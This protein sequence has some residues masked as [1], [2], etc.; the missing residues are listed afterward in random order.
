MTASGEVWSPSDFT[1]SPHP[2]P[3]SSKPK[4]PVKLGGRL[5]RT[6]SGWQLADAFTAIA[7]SGFLPDNCQAGDLLLLQGSMI[8]ERFECTSG[9]LVLHPTCPPVE[10]ERLQLNGLG[11]RLASRSWLFQKI[12]EFFATRRFI[13]V[14]TPIRTLER[15]LEENIQPLA[16]G[17]SLLITSPELHMK[18]LLV[19]GVPRLFELVHCFRDGEKGQLHH[20]EFLMLEWYRA[21][22]DQQAVMRDTEELLQ[23]LCFQLHGNSHLT[24]WGG[25]EIDLSTPFETLTIREV[26]RRFGGIDDAVKLASEDENQYFQVLV[27]SVEP[28][29]AQFSK[30][31]FLCEYPASQAALARL[32]PQDPTVA[33][34]FELYVGGVELCNGYGE[35]NDADEQRRRMQQQL[36]RATRSEQPQNQPPGPAPKLP[37]R[38]LSALDQGMPPAGG[39]A[40]GVDRLMALLTGQAAIDA[41]MPFAEFPA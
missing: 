21:F 23:A 17:E 26:F 30:P 31:V 3:S 20:P 41:V 36:A 22:S 32:K 6:A 5:Q 1:A 40:L 7:L 15:C 8:E 24:L 11:S 10:F 13:E 18:R 37:Q 9:E 12:R 34:R 29:L 39:N 33:E 14:D 2:R 16:S 19:A 35:L 4:E 38:F 28:A 25:R 27:D